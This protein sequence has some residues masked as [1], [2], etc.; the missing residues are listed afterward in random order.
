MGLG[1]KDG[2]N[3]GVD[4]SLRKEKNFPNQKDKDGGHHCQLSKKVGG[5]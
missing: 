4:N 5:C 3:N 2:D 1:K